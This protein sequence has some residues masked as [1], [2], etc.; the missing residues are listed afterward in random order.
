MIFFLSSYDR[1]GYFGLLVPPRECHI[2]VQLWY[3]WQA[4]Q[5]IILFF[6]YLRLNFFFKI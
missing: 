4:I 3:L 6:R 1:C 5:V 2:P